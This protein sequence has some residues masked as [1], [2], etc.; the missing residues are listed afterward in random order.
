MKRPFW[1]EANCNFCGRL[2]QKRNAYHGRIHC[3]DQ[4]Y[5]AYVSRRNKDL[6]ATRDRTGAN[7]PGWKGDAVT[8]WGL[9]KRANKLKGPGPCEQCHAK[10]QVVH[11]K[12][13]NPRNNDLSNLERLCRACHARHHGRER[14]GINRSRA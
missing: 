4:C 10:G 1:I 11:H 3:S 14:G 2:Y 9:H 13:E 6:A 7:A 12:D 5:S 8:R